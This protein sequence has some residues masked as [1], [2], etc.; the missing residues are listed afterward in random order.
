MSITPSAAPA[1][2]AAGDHLPH[3]G[4]WMHSGRL[5]RDLWLKR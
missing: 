1:S 5:Q 3:S 2:T 4:R